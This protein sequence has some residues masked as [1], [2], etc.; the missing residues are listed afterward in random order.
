[1]ELPVSIQDSV[2]GR[3]SLFQWGMDPREGKETTEGGRYRQRKEDDQAPRRKED[4]GCSLVIKG[5]S[6]CEI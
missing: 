6:S 4:Q 1:M 5:I 3:A 2:A